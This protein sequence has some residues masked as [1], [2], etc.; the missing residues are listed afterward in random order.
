M[1]MKQVD[2]LII[3]FGV[4]GL[5][6]TVA[7]HKRGQRVAVF[8]ADQPYTS[9]RSA[10]A[11]INPITGRKY[12]LSWKV[13]EVISA[14]TAYYS[15]L[16]AFTGNTIFKKQPI[17]RELHTIEAENNWAAKHDT[18]QELGYVQNM[19]AQ[20]PANINSNAANWIEIQGGGQVSYSAYRHAVTKLIYQGGHTYK[21]DEFDYSL[22]HTENGWWYYG[23]DIATKKVIFCEGS[24][25]INNR[26]IPKDIIE[27]GKGES[28]I[29]YFVNEESEMFDPEFPILKKD[30]FLVPM[31]AGWYWVGSTLDFEDASDEPTSQG[32]EILENA[33][34][35]MTGFRF[36][37]KVHLAGK[38]PTTYDRR[39][40]LGEL[41]NYK[42]LF[43]L[44][45]LGTKGF[46]LAPWCAEKLLDK[47]V[48]PNAAEIDKEI[49]INR[50][51]NTSA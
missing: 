36:I 5:S 2:I 49:S 29:G 15:E 34:K 47:M 30:K 23:K 33:V 12:N 41:P 44:N 7:A 19:F 24:N 16:E 31:G 51:V 1:R 27:H 8:D 25:C 32:K 3:G 4:A 14:S 42:N 38:R 28:L 17:Y 13:E 37:I 43:I 48:V 20:K 50:F 6:A 35:E 39:P 45:G 40:I 26:F 18:Y 11:I 10:G 21:K 9:S 22:L 46:S